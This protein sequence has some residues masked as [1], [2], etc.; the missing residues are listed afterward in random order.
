[1]K[2]ENNYKKKK[3]YQTQYQESDY[4]QKMKQRQE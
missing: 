4:L 3:T 2:E 1:M